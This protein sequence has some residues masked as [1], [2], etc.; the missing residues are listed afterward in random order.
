[1]VI[2][3]SWKYSSA[4]K[5]FQ[6]PHYSMH[7]PSGNVNKEDNQPQE[8]KHLHH[9]SNSEDLVLDYFPLSRS[10]LLNDLTRRS[11]DAGD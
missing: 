8:C 10:V 5:L 6:I 7:K 4:W 11:R 3:L 9:A 2:C 1:M